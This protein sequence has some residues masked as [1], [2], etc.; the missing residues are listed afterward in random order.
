MIVCKL[1]VAGLKKIKRTEAC[2]LWPVGDERYEYEK[3]G[4]T[5]VRPKASLIKKTRS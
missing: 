4:G 3:H 2:G 1:P 5:T